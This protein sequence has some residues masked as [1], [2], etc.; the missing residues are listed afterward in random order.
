MR[1]CA[2]MTKFINDVDIKVKYETMCGH[3]NTD[4]FLLML[5]CIKESSLNLALAMLK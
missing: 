5:S 2:V 3:E 1:K 4:V